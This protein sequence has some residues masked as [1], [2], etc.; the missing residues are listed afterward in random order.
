MIFYVMMLTVSDEYSKFVIHVVFFFLYRVWKQLQLC[1]V[2][3]LLVLLLDPNILSVS[4]VSIV[5]E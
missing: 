4:Q 3:K 1:L 2:E 5:G